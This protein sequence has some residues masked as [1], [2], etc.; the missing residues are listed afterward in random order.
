MTLI[1]GMNIEVIR[2]MRIGMMYI[3]GALVGASAIAAEGL[4]GL[5]DPTRPGAAPAYVESAAPAAAGPV[6][7][8]TLIA[9]GVK[10]A[11]ISGKTYTV[12]EKVGNAVVSDIRPYEVM[13]NQGGRE[14]RLR[15]VPPLAKEATE[16]SA[17]R[18]K[19][20]NP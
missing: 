13:L 3:A 10:R 16:Q 7:Q 8:S 2:G 20:V 15:L 12:G 19:G 4:A 5:A 14:T 9:P 17:G 11:M 6:L 1:R 18:K